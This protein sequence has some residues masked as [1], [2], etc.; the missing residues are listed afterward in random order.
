MFGVLG[1][2]FCRGW[3]ILGVFL[4]EGRVGVLGGSRRVL[5]IVQCHN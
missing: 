4:G 1:T 2:A 5:G 3:V